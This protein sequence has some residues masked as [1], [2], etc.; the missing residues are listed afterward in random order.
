MPFTTGDNKFATAKWI[1]SA[2][3]G[4]GTH[5]TIASA[6][7]SASSGDT[8]AIKDG[9][10]TE[11]LTLKAGVALVGWDP[12][13]VTIVGKCTATTAGIFW[14]QNI[15][16]QTN[17]DF[18][19]DISGSAATVPIFYDCLFNGT[20]ASIL[21][22][23]SSNASSV[24]GFRNCQL[25]LATTGI[26][27]FIST[28]AG[29][30]RFSNCV[31]NNTGISTTA[32]TISAGG[33]VI[34]YSEVYHTITT[35]GTGSIDC[36]HT[37]MSTT[38]ISTICLTHGGS[39]VSTL[40]F[41][42]FLPGSATAFT[43]TAT[44]TCSNISVGSSNVSTITGAGTIIYDAI[45]FYGTTSAMTVTTQTA[46][47]NIFGTSKFND[48]AVGTPAITFSAD[49]DTGIY[50]VGTNNMALVTAGASAEII[51]AAGEITKPLQPAFL[52]VASDQTDV[53]GDSTVY[54]IIF[55]NEI[56]DQNADFD[57][58]STFTAPITGRYQINTTLEIGGIL[59]GHTGGNANLV[60]SN[61]SVAFMGANYGAVQTSTN[62]YRVSGAVLIDMDVGDTAIVQVTVTGST[63]VIDVIATNSTFS[64]ALTC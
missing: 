57:G 39:G 48:G 46:R 45:H 22:F 50:R 41:V 31:L 37:L 43:T 60:T 4:L 49:T 30:M 26:A 42:D 17:G 3:A 51:S 5:T 8:I 21:S 23:S 35:S 15:T 33:L 56:F 61:R 64:A 18:C 11:N 25:N 32:S 14:C 63:K 29:A 58:T 62:R 40:T 10:Y 59:V 54:T 52:A 53:T 19:L 24:I 12:V 1:V 20:N 38:N 9:T 28:S 55:A 16:F 27:T 13:N 34:Y 2:T 6:L 36:R 44:I 7:T 47:S